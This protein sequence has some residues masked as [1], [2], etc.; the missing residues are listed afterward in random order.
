MRPGWLLL[1]CLL[2]FPPG[3]HGAD[4][5]A[6]I[7][8][9]ARVL[10]HVRL[11][12]PA[13]PNPVNVTQADLARGYVEVARHYR[14]STNAP[15][16]VLLQFNPRLGLAEAVDVEGFGPTLRLEDATLEVA[17]ATA[18]DF[19]LRFRLWLAPGVVPGDYPLP[20]QLAAVL[21]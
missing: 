12:A 18:G 7:A 4:V 6:Q 19:E 10:P 9:S 13:T 15:D 17:P 16:R 2:G 21:R 8:V 5:A 3:S 20:W 11:E 1:A 14:L